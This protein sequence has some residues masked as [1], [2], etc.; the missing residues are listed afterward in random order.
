MRQK[1][2]E[3]NYFGFSFL[4]SYIRFSS[5]S[6]QPDYDRLDDQRFRQQLQ[7]RGNKQSRKG[8][9]D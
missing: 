9:N 7:S 3:D 5:L 8:K 2:K 1:E 6:F 4:F